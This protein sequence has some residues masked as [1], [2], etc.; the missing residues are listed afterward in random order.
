MLF[1][2][3]LDDMYYVGCI[4]ILYEFGWLFVWELNDG[5]L[6]R[7]HSMGEEST[8]LWWRN[9]L[10]HSNADPLTENESQRTYPVWSVVFDIWLIAPWELNDGCLGRIHYIAW[11]TCE[12]QTKLQS[13]PSEDTANLDPVQSV[14]FDI[15]LIAPWELNDGCL[16]RIHYMVTTHFF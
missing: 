14:V 1:G 16:T 12:Q 3:L 7:N 10:N 15:W 11:Q 6:T 5:W 2:W 4:C 8:R 13:I 9:F